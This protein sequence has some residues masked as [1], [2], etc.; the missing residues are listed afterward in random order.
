V[1]I[2]NENALPGAFDGRR[3]QNARG[4]APLPLPSLEAEERDMSRQEGAVHVVLGATGGIGSEVCR[5]LKEAGAKLV[6]GAR[7]EARLHQLAEE[8]GALP[9]AGDA[10]EFDVAEAAVRAAVAEH[11]RVDGIVN[12]VGSILLKPAHTTSAA[13]L[14]DILRT[15]LFS[16]FAAVRAA[17]RAMR[18]SGGS[19]V[20]LSTAAARAGLANHEAIAAAK[21]GV[22]AMARSAAATYAPKGIRINVIAPGLVDTPL[23]ERITSTPAAREASESMHALGRLGTP[24]DVASAICFLLD[25]ENSWITGQV[26]GVDGGLA[27]LR[28]R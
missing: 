9:V 20:L 11:G 27:T 12:C 19:V 3:D 14:D 4:G 25:P 17:G 16:A 24:G 1:R 7:D 5:R 15:N 8:V 13:E 26:L 28:A 21:G 23:S 10:C 22:T 6:I 2:R 18:R